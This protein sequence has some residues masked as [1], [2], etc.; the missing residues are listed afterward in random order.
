MLDRRRNL[1]T[2]AS[3]PFGQR[4]EEP[5]HRCGTR[6]RRSSLP[7]F[8]HALRH[9]RRALCRRLLPLETQTPIVPCLPESLLNGLA[10]YRPL[11][12]KDRSLHPP[13]AV[14]IDQ[15]AAFWQEDGAAAIQNM[16]IATTAL[17]YG[18][19]WVQGRTRPHETELKLV[20]GIPA[21]RHLM[22]LVPVGVPDETPMKEKKAL[23]DV[24][25]W[26]TYPAQNA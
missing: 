1:G 25:Y 16:L 11:S 22:S 9:R 6:R 10:G 19:C 23:D 15:S 14:V 26:E 17:G 12:D 3:R 7:R 24:L 2:G 18:A 4:A 21:K 13:I 5:D 8:P 20:L